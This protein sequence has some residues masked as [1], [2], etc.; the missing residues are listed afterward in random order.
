MKNGVRAANHRE[1]ALPRAQAA[2]RQVERDEGRGARG[3]QRERRPLDVQKEREPPRGHVRA[4]AG[5]RVGIELP[6]RCRRPE[7]H[8]R[9]IHSIDSDENAGILPAERR[10]GNGASSSAWTVSS[11]S[12]R[13]CGSMNRA[14]FSMMPK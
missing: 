8:Q 14:S 10:G 13:C 12:I 1:F 7:A 2:H 3:V 4:G 6:Q 11:S 9:L 5:P